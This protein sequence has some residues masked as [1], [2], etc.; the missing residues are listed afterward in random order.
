MRA[1]IA[2]RQTVIHHEPPRGTHHYLQS[3]LAKK[4]KK[5]DQPWQRPSGTTFW[6]WEHNAK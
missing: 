4:K 3:S 1:H 2:E 5:K 6:E